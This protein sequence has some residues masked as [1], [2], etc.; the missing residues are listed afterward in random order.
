VERSVAAEALA[1][2][3]IGRPMTVPGVNVIGAATLVAAIGAIGRFPTS[4]KLVGHPGLDASIGPARSR[5]GAGGSPGGARP[6]RAGRWSR[7][8]GRSSAGPDRG[9]PS[10]SGSAPGAAQRVAVLAAARKLAV[11]LW[12]PLTGGADHAHQQ[13]SPTQKKLRPLEIRAGAP[14]LAGTDTGTFATRERMRAAERELA[15]QAEAS[16]AHGL[17]P[18]GDGEEEGGRE[19]DTGARIW[20]LEGQGRAA[21]H[22]PPTPALRYVIGPRPPGA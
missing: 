17:R 6:R 19:R 10:T 18:A 7:R 2:P 9:T 5:R 15:A 13:P 4:R 12:C 21:G 8:A 20:A 22:R 3:E 11:P 16:H 14:T 1:S